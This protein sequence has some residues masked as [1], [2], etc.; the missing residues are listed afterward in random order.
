MDANKLGWI[1]KEYQS[2][3][4]ILQD[5]HR[6]RRSYGWVA[7]WNDGIITEYNQISED[8]CLLV[9]GIIDQEDYDNKSLKLRDEAIQ[10]GELNILKDA[11]FPLIKII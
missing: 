3:Y 6:A 7:I 1:M 5:M 4:T 9:S 8:C 11:E 10:E 2:P